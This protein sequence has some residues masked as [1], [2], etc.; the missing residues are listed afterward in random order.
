MG[1]HLS[2]VTL[3]GRYISSVDRYVLFLDYNGN[4]EYHVI[5]FNSKTEMYQFNFRSVHT[6]ISFYPTYRLRTRSLHSPTYLYVLFYLLLLLEISL[7]YTYIVY[8]HTCKKARYIITY[9]KSAGIIGLY[10]QCIHLLAGLSRPYIDAYTTCAA[11]EKLYFG[12]YTNI[13]F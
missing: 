1:A 3:K 2:V 10:S 6:P 13:I 7:S 11:G 4:N 9:S 8:I 12:P 5:P